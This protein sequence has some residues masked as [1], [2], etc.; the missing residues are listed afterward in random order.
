MFRNRKFWS[1]VYIIGVAIFLYLFTKTIINSAPTKQKI[2]ASSIFSRQV[3]FANSAFTFNYQKHAKLLFA[4]GIWRFDDASFSDIAHSVRIDCLSHFGTCKK[5]VISINTINDKDFIDVDIVD[6]K[7]IKW[8]EQQIIAQYVWVFGKGSQST[9]IVD[10][11]DKSIRVTS[12]KET[13]LKQSKIGHYTD[14]GVLIDGSD[15]AI[16][17][18]DNRLAWFK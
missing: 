12:S 7:I 18:G 9:L 3:I 1:V 15:K 14:N 10:L 17:I 13:P 5:T 6:F 4:T 16:S 2:A 8:N 11:K